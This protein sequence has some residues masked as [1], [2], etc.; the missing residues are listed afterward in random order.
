[1]EWWSGGVVEYWN[2]GILEY[3]SARAVKN[4]N[5]FS[6][7]GYFLDDFGFV[8]ELGDQLF[9]AVYFDAWFSGVRG[10]DF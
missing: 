3:W 2:D 4:R 9:H 1:M 5:F 7:I 8:T 10:F 6:A